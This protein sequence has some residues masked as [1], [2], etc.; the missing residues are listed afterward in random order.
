M[1]NE[2]FWPRLRWAAATAVGSALLASQLTTCELRERWRQELSDDQRQTIRTATV[3]YVGVL[4]GG[5]DQALALTRSGTLG[6]EPT[7]EQLDAYILEQRKVGVAVHT[8]GAK[9]YVENLDVHFAVDSLYEQWKT[10]DIK[11]IALA[12]TTVSPPMSKQRQWCHLNWE[13]RSVNV[14]ATL[15]KIV[16]AVRRPEIE[17][18]KMETKAPANSRPFKPPPYPC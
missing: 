6:K 8:A 16:G 4:I 13:V 3:E 15:D 14:T 18:P 17:P 11:I 1:D 2:G 9:L 12:S 10:L 5:L 7:P